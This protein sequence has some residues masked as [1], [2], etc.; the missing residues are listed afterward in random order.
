VWSSGGFLFEAGAD[1]VGEGVGGDAAGSAEGEG[2]E[3]VGAEEA[4]D[5]GAAE[6]EA[7]HDLG[8]GEEFRAG[9]HA[10]ALDRTALVSRS[11]E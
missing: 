9:G 6:L 4:V 7:F 8:D 10:M 2:G 5:G 1:E 3:L 11:V